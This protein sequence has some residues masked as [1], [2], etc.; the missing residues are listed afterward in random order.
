MTT[1]WVKATGKLVYE[2]KRP[3]LRKTRQNDDWWLIVETDPR[4]ANYYNWWVERMWGL[5]LQLPAWKAHVTVLDGR[6]PVKPEFRNMWKAHAGEIITF[7]YNVEFEQHWKF[8][9][10]PVRSKKLNDYRKE[11]GFKPI[12]NMHITFGRM[13]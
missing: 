8:F 11:L 13:V 12:N 9:A 1:N 5:R 6:Y 3:E 10:L 2:P 7:E 4:I